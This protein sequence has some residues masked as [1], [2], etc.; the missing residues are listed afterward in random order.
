MTHLLIYSASNHFS[1]LVGDG[2]GGAIFLFSDIALKKKSHDNSLDS[3]TKSRRSA[4]LSGEV[5]VTGFLALSPVGEAGKKD[6]LGRAV[7]IE[8]NEKARKIT[9]MRRTGPELGI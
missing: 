8:N 5:G 1:G 3:T 2:C 4:R 6:G 7:C 9:V